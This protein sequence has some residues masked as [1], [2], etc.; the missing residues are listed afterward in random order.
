MGLIFTAIAQAPRRVVTAAAPA[1]TALAALTLLAACTPQT[2]TEPY[3]LS[4]SADRCQAGQSGDDLLA[5]VNS[6]YS[7]TY[8][9]P[10]PRPP[11]APPWA[12]T[13][14]PGPVEL[15]VAFTGGRMVC[16]PAR[17]PPCPA[18]APCAAPVPA[19]VSVELAFVFTTPDGS[20]KETFTGTA[21]LRA[22]EDKVLWNARLPASKTSGNYP[23]ANPGAASLGL[24]FT[25]SFAGDANTSSISQGNISETTT[26]AS[27]GAGEWLAHATGAPLLVAAKKKP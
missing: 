23:F 27:F 15:L 20:F 1:L 2:S 14:A 13:A 22:G 8:T 18:N 7:G 19:A 6:G 11:D 5:R 16:S 17:S 12:G 26:T 3:P 24:F 21:T 25:G 4:R 9:P 10:A